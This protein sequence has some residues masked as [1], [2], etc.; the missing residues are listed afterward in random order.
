MAEKLTVKLFLEKAVSIPVL[1][2]RSP[3]EYKQGHIPGA[4]SFPLFSDEERKV[5]GTLYKQSGHEPAFLAGLEIVGPKMSAFVRE[6]VLIC[7]EKQ[8][9]VHCWRGGMR[10]SSMAWLLETAG[11]K[12]SIL[13]GGYKSF[14]QSVLNDTPFDGPFL[15]LGGYTGSG[16]TPVLHGLALKGEQVLDLENLAHHK[17]S[18]FGGLDE[19]EQPTQEQFENEI[20][21]FLN[22]CDSNRFVWI[23]DESKAIGRLRV[24]NDVYDKLRSSSLIFLE[25]SR[26]ARLKRIEML[27]G[28]A[29]PEILCEFI[30]KLARRLGGLRLKNALEAINSGDISE[31]AS[32]VLE[33]YDR[34]YLHGLELRESEKSFILNCSEVEESGIPDLLLQKAVELFPEID[35]I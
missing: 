23:E 21:S 7:P 3:G 16:K 30:K 29:N 5:V 12:V 20:F 14:R 17:G 19:V 10:S 25:Q 34:S 6:A 32:V 18:V 8:V 22:S 31:A 2:V 9:A 15:V 27:Y 33:Y 28:N 4:I 13:I 1:D 35:E 26:E 24:P 11:F